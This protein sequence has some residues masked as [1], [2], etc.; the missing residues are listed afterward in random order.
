MRSRG[1]STVAVFVGTKGVF[2]EW[3]MQAS[4]EQPG[5]FDNALDLQR[6]TLSTLETRLRPFRFDR[7]STVQTAL[8]QIT[9]GPL[10]WTESGGE[11]VYSLYCPAVKSGPLPH[12]TTLS[13]CGIEDSD[14]LYT[15][16]RW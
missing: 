7:E 5:K 11:Y 9:G 3:R 12:D 16:A 4:V 1:A 13:G 10:K 15:D 14:V 8:L 2:D 6:A